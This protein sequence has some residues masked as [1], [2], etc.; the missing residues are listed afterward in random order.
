M[1]R[2]E[3]KG[4]LQVNQ[5]VDGDY[6][7]RKDLYFGVKCVGK[8]AKKMAVAYERELNDGVTLCEMWN[9]GILDKGYSVV[10]DTLSQLQCRRDFD[11]FMNCGEY[12]GK[13]VTK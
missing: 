9:A 6:V 2:T 11:K 7:D 10:F 3:Y 1:R 4:Y 13:G 8:K 5:W 12:V